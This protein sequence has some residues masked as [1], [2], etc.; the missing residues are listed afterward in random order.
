MNLEF[1]VDR[2]NDFNPQKFNGVLSLHQIREIL[3]KL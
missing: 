2:T 3:I 1:H